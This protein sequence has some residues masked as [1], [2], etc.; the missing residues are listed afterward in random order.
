MVQFTEIFKV[1]QALDWRFRVPEL[2]VLICSFVESFYTHNGSIHFL[3][4]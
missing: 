2:A 3:R 1:L 4:R